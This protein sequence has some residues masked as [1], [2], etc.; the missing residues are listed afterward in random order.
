MNGS[1]TNGSS[2]RSVNYRETGKVCCGRRWRFRP[3]L[4]ATG[5]FLERILGFFCVPPSG[6][7]PKVDGLKPVGAGAGHPS[8][9]RS[10]VWDG[11]SPNERR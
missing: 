3:E 11:F 6:A 9:N 1:D 5:T 8:R 2:H 7:R 10:S 4:P